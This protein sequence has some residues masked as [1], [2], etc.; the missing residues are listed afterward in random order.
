MD[1]RSVS[2]GSDMV[3]DREANMYGKSIV[4]DG[5]ITGTRAT[6]NGDVTVN[7]SLNV[8]PQLPE[9]VV[10]NI[11][12]LAS[13]TYEYYNVPDML[14]DHPLIRLTPVNYADG[15]GSIDGS[16]PNP[17][18]I[19]NAVVAQPVDEMIPNPQRATDIFWLFGQVVDHDL[20]LTPSNPSDPLNIPVPSGD[21]FFDPSG[22]GTVVIAFN[23]SRV[24][25]GTGV[26]TPR[27]FVTEITYELDLSSVYGSCVPRQNWLRQF[28]RGLLKV[29][30]GNSLPAIAPG[31]MAAICGNDG[32]IGQNVFVAGDARANEN[33]ALLSIHNLWVR[34][35]NWWA[36]QIYALNKSFS[37]EHI[38]QLARLQCIAENQAI[39][40]NEFVPLLLGP[41]ALPEYTGYKPEVS[42]AVSIEFATAAFRIGHTFVSEVLLRQNNDGTT[43]EPYGNLQLL[44]GFFDPGEYLNN[45]DLGLLLRGMSRQICQR[46]DTKIV[47][48]IRNFL[49]GPPGAGGHDLAA[50]NIQRGRDHGLSKYNAARVALGMSPKATFSDITSDSAIA[51]ALSSAYGGDISKVD[52]WV[53][54]LAEDKVPGG[55]QCGELFQHILVDQFTRSRDGDRLFYKNRLPTSQIAYVDSIRLRDIIERNTC[56]KNLQEYVMKLD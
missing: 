10:Q 38:Y 51:S 34:E 6:F 53:G 39:I 55:S 47:N 36:Q 49:F 44:D 11:Q 12:T 1:C 27:E 33:T 31:E 13:T 41:N 18:F 7:G 15:I 45:G 30:L 20:D 56:A 46:M 5:S 54:G 50:L 21:P 2:I 4:V 8:V 25:S 3:I 40:Y 52:L 35:H 23:R 16:L 22:T 9:S 43:A 24:R 19:S 29:G 42:I 26:T 48:A 17:R 28:W 14:L 32:P 37:D